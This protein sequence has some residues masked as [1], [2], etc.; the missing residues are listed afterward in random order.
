[1]LLKQLRDPVKLV[2]TIIRIAILLSTLLTEFLCLRLGIRRPKRTGALQNNF[3][4]VFDE[5]DNREHVVYSCSRPLSP[6]FP[7][8][9][10]VRNGPNPQYTP[11][12]GNYHWF[13]GD[14]HL[15]SILIEED[16]KVRYKNCFVRTEK[17]LMEKQHQ[18]PILYGIAHK[19]NPFIYLDY[20]FQ[21][22]FCGLKSIPN[23]NAA[24]TSIEYHNGKCLAL[25][26]AGKPHEIE[27]PS[28]E[29][30]GIYDFNGQL[31]HH[32]TAHP[33]L[34]PVTGDLI[35]F[36]YN[37]KPSLIHYSIANKKGEIV[38]DVNFTEAPFS[39]MMHDFACTEKYTLINYFPFKLNPQLILEGRVPFEMDD[40]DVT[41]IAVI[42]RYYQPD[43][44]EIKW[45]TVKKGYSFHTV[46]AYDDG[47]WIVMRC[48]FSDDMTLE[49]FEQDF[50][51]PKFN[52]RLYEWKLN[53]KT[54]EVKERSLLFRNESHMEEDPK[55]L[56]CDFP[57]IN[58]DYECRK[59]RYSWVALTQPD[60]V[61]M[62]R[63]CKVDFE[64]MTYRTHSFDPSHISGEWSLVKKL[65]AKNEDDVYAMSFVYN[66]KAKTSSFQVI[67]GKT[68]EKDTL[69]VFPLPRRVP[70]GFHGKFITK[71]EYTAQT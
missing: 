63:L 31:K 38:H 23:H 69:S 5:L 47:D 60:N 58:D 16:R 4:P 28:L 59:N 61:L 32:M 22:V 8:G 54:G 21:K 1:M 27:L 15:H 30:K 48:C 33:K 67:D 26:E 70:H 13:D 42:P 39:T 50:T 11:T 6:D 41:K 19:G 20:L 43:K 45:F 53:T 40:K 18:Q 9:I 52:P 62:G 36:A 29:T 68:L 2:H 24:N 7:P 35:F 57:V 37:V 3:A 12:R 56:F 51:K 49:L 65:N 44:D 10:F 25:F 34:D 64:K 17:Y 71:S 46:N 55:E 66:E 14:G